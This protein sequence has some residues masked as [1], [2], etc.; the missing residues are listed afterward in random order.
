MARLDPRRCDDARQPRGT[1]VPHGPGRL[2]K[3]GSYLPASLFRASR[4]A[5]PAA[6]P[7]VRALDE[8]V[9]GRRELGET[10]R[11][12]ELER[13]LGSAEDGLG[14]AENAR[15]GVTLEGLD[16][17]LVGLAVHP[18]ANEDP[19]AGLPFIERG[20]ADTYDRH[21]D[22]MVVTPEPFARQ[23]RHT[24]TESFGADLDRGLSLRSTDGLPG[25]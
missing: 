11:L 6:E 4:W 3:S 12:R 24:E 14:R 8:T 16:P 10:L 25:W 17:G 21:D 1:G 20:I 15:R 13:G 5:S 2:R 23:V 19:V 7:K 18:E 22:S 9:E